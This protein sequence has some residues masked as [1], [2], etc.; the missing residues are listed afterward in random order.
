MIRKVVIPAA[1][2]GIRF[3]PATKVIPKEMIPVAGRPLIQYAVEEAAASE[4]ETV[5]LVV[6]SSKG[7]I[8]RHFQPDLELERALRGL[9]KS[10][11]AEALRKLSTL[12]EVRTVFQ[13]KPRGLADAIRCARP[14][15]EDEPFA[16]ILPDALVIS[17]TPCIKQLI[18]CYHNHPG[19]IIA[20]REVQA[21]EVERFGILDCL[22]SS[23]PSD[24]GKVL[25]VAALI[26]RP[27][28]NMVA[29]R[30]GIFGRYILE[31][32]IFDF[33]D[34]ARPGLGG[35]LQLTDSLALCL[36]RLP[37]YAYFFEGQHYDVG[38]KLGHTMAMLA[39]ALKDPD[40]EQPVREYLKNQQS[41]SD[42]VQVGTTD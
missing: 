2:K 26:E 4:I 34:V 11:E 24:E 14:L 7:A 13:D 8:S 5:I 19:N 20:T 42:A 27:K 18:T 9:G 36:K 29:S 41:I 22:P 15:I 12:A 10:E 33:I 16:V 6:S 37:V 40:L 31:P 35:E 23:G 21:E 1:G 32:N 25:C 17:K 30:Y 39:L 3:L 38:N 28:P